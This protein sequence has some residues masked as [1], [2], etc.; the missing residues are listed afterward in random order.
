MN[1]PAQVP[2]AN[3]DYLNVSR[4]LFSLA[5]MAIPTQVSGLTAAGTELRDVHTGAPVQ[6]AGKFT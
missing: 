5:S 3:F 6:L 1:Q 2:E 4:M